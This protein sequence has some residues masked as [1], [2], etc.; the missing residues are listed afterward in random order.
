MKK[1]WSILKTKLFPPPHHACSVP[2][3]EAMLCLDCDCLSGGGTCCFCGS[4]SVHSV[5]RWVDG[6]GT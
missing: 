2:W 3:V 6:M 4:K 1:L 5:S